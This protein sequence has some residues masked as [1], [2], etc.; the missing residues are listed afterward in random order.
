MKVAAS[1]I[2]FLLL[3]CGGPPE[4]AESPA[5]PP[6][7][8]PAPAEEAAPAPEAPPAEEAAPEPAPV[9]AA[10][11]DVT[12]KLSE[13]ALPASLYLKWEIESYGTIIAE[14]Y[15]KDAP[16]NVTNIANLAIEG[17]YD[18]LTFHRIVPGFVVQGGD[19]KGTGAGG[20]GYTV[21]AEIA[22]KHEKGCLAMARKPDKVNPKKESSGCQFYFCLDDLTE[23]DGNY[24]VIGKIVEGLEVM[25]ALGAA[26]TGKKEKPKKK[27]VMKKVTVLTR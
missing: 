3:G 27:I 24:T 16:K 2:G 18:G 19:P 4:P 6:A 9:P 14:L 13:G 12:E 20:T 11:S 21:P 10:Y 7:E 23:L 5:A 8:E 25:E 1:L 26:E 15:T 17:F 22:R